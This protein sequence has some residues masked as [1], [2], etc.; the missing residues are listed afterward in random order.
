[1]RKGLLISLLV[2]ALAALGVFAF[3]E[4]IMGAIVERLTRDMFV[5][6]DTDAFDPGVSVG[7][8]L[9]AI[10]ARLEDREVTDIGE[11]M[12][13]RGA[14]LIANRSVDW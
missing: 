3:R 11:F 12:G 4:P 2:V 8:A 14:V 1:M 10:R 9:P 5:A 6:T 7:S 13:E